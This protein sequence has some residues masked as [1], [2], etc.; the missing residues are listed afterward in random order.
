MSKE[1]DEAIERFG[2]QESAGFKNLIAIKD[3]TLATRK[4]IQANDK[5][6]EELKQLI[7]GQNEII[8][9]LRTQIQHLQ[10]KMAGNGSTT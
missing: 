9:G 5:K 4:L 6:V 1:T 10:I 3:Y 8:I 7:V 2:I